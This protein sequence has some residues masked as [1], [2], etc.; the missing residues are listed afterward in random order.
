VRTN[1]K[2]ESLIVGMDI[3]STGTRW[4]LS[5]IET[6]IL[7]EGTSTELRGPW[8]EASQALQGIKALITSISHAPLLALVIG[9]TGSDSKHA[10]GLAHALSAQFDLALDRIEIMSD[11]ELACLAH[12]E[13]GEG[14]L[15]YAGTGSIAG[16]WDSSLSFYRCG[17]RGPLIDD[18]GGGHWIARQA[19]QHIWRSEESKPGSLQTMP[20]A[21]RLC[22]AMQAFDWPSQRA[23]INQADRG[24]FGEL[25]LAVASEVDEDSEAILRAAGQALARLANTMVDNF[26]QRPIGLAGGAFS[27]HPLIKQSLVHSL[28]SPLPITS[29]RMPAAQ[30]ACIFAQ[31]KLAKQTPNAE[32]RLFSRIALAGAAASLSA[33][34]STPTIIDARSYRSIGFESRALFLIIHYTQLNLERS[35]EVLTRGQVSSHY[36]LSDESPPRIYRLVDE[37][38][39]AF[40]A[41]V[42][43]WAG[44]GNLNSASIGIEIVHPG[45]VEQADGSQS[46]V[47]YPESQIDALI[48]LV[49]DIMKRHQIRADRVL[50]HSDIA[51]QRKIDP[52]PLFPWKRLAQEGLIRWPDEAMVAER[53]PAFEAQL[54]SLG[55]FQGQLSRLGYQVD[56]DG[57]STEATRRVVA[58][59]QMRYRPSR[60]DGKPDAHTAA[61]LAVLN[62]DK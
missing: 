59:F 49:R 58:A 23:W 48:P 27:L 14:Y 19:L 35:I 51:P 12:F 47:P 39:R 13:P 30:A 45:V 53:L 42:S 17:G 38:L 36:L 55:W 26:G 9:I 10:T 44:H 31:R 11:I 18:A 40:H 20:L 16:F 52:G 3:G 8:A 28:T 6:Q 7:A 50:G 37:N 56:Q 15:I 43:Y 33:C 57:Q 54:P 46:F 34:G 5:D 32:R 2:T 62:Q 61:L 24:K 22:E 21:R 4:C 60:Y 1:Q 25:A 29:A 41:G